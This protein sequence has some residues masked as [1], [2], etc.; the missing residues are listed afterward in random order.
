MPGAR[1]EHRLSAALALRAGATED[2]AP[3][4]RIAAEQCANPRVRIALERIAEGSGEEAAVEEALA[5]ERGE[6]APAASPDPRLRG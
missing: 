3:H 5:E 6:H 2:V 1:L 4:L